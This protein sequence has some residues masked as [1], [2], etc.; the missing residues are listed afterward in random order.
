MTV[1]ELIAELR[2]MPQN[3]KVGWQDHD[4][5]ENDLNAPVGYV[6]RADAEAIERETGYAGIGVVLRP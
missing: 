2:K 6:E 4:H 1:R 3:A 5:G